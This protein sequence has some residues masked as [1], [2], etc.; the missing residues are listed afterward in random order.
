MVT[1]YELSMVGLSMHTAPLAIREALSFTPTEATALLQQAAACLPHLEVVLL[2]TCNRTE[3]Y[4]AASPDA[5]DMVRWQMLLQQSRPVLTQEA[6]RKRLTP[7]Y[8]A[9]TV[10]HLFRVACGL[11]SA[12]V[13]DV[14]ILGQVKEAIAIADTA[15]TLGPTLRHTFHQALQV[16]K[17]ARSTTSIGHGAASLGSAL[18]HML[19]KYYPLTPGARRPHTLI[20]GAGDAARNIGQHLATHRLGPLTF[21]NRTDA[22]ATA[23]AQECAGHSVAWATLPTVLGEADVIIAATMAP[24]PILRRDVLT[25]LAHYRAWRPPLIIDA[26]LP[27][28]VE[29]GSS[30]PVIDLDAIQ[31]RQED[32]LAQRRAAIPH[33]EQLITDAQHAWE[34]WHTAQPVEAMIK[35]LYQ[36]AA[37]L[38]QEVARTLTTQ[39]TLNTAQTERVV[40]QAFK[41]LLADHV[42]QLRGLPTSRRQGKTQ[43]SHSCPHH[44]SATSAKVRYARRATLS[45]A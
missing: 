6:W 24:H 22:K 14:Q 28:N 15:G 41:Q 45:H 25:A 17:H 29:P 31:E 2:A 19:L 35:T 3:F 7:R 1:P 8:G 43:P 26:G 13:G 36:E 11:D 38:S 42:R 33:V 37:S 30:L 20:I 32:V 39:G 4:L 10:R 9:E 12:I 23:L 21:I 44:T 5:S 34:Q 18:A 16:G 40:M 27:R